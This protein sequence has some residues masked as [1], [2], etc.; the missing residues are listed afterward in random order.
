[1]AEREDYECPPSDVV[2]EDAD[3]ADKASNDNKLA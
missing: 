2:H 1:M 3:R